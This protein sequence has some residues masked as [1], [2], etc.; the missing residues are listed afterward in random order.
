MS[1][2]AGAAAIGGIASLA[3]TYM[4]NS[5][6][7][8]VAQK[9]MDFQERMSSTAYQRAMADMKAAGLNP[10]L[11][12]KMGGASTPSG[13]SAEMKD[14]LGPA[15]NTALSLYTG[16]AQ[17]KRTVAETNLL[18]AQANTE[19]AKYL[20]EKIVKEGIDKVKGFFGS[21]NPRHPLLGASS[22]LSTT[23]SYG[24]RLLPASSALSTVKNYS[25]RKTKDLIKAAGAADKVMYEPFHDFVR[26]IFGS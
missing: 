23:K 26:W 21:P 5:A 4:T 18:Q 19:D 13:A 1:W 12:G 25:Q 3:G 22:A 7:A 20:K 6:N 11:A 8:A 24:D 10:I 2:D 17:L 14:P 9:Q 15:V 16:L